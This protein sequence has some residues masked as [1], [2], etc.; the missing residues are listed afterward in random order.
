MLIIAFN[1]TEQGFF[2]MF[3]FST[4][5]E[6]FSFSINACNDNDKQGD[7]VSE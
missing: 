7:I 5:P 1:D 4:N 2:S 6:M 3:F